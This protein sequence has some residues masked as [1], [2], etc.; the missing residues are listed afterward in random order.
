MPSTV[1][2]TWYR[3]IRF[4]EDW[5]PGVEAWRYLGPDDLALTGWAPPAPRRQ[6]FRPSPGEGEGV[7]RIGMV[8]LLLLLGCQAGTPTA[9]PT[10]AG[11]VW[12]PYQPAG[13]GFLVQMPGVPQETRDGDYRVAT[14]GPLQVRYRAIGPLD[15]NK[16]LEMIQGDE[17][18]KRGSVSRTTGTYANG[19]PALEGDVATS[20]GKPF[21]MRVFHHQYRLYVLSADGP[22]A[23]RF[24]DSFDIVEVKG[25][26]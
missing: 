22:D 7:S 2:V 17:M 24:L 10:S 23:Q 9:E 3:W 18:R 4:E 15:R 25:G 13:G 20:D 12:H 16:S 1:P 14:L 6:E 5:P 21:R 26:G 8:L 19:R 11:P